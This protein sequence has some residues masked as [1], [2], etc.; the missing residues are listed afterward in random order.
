MSTIFNGITHAL[1]VLFVFL[2]TFAIAASVMGLFGGV[3]PTEARLALVEALAAVVL[4]MRF[5]QRPA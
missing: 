1:E 3:G 5:I 4:W 2:A